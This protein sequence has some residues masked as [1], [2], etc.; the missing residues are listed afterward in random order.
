MCNV[1]STSCKI[2]GTLLE[3]LNETYGGKSGENLPFW[4]VDYARQ[5]W[6][7]SLIFN[8]SGLDWRIWFNAVE[9]TIN[10]AAE[11]KIGS[12]QIPGK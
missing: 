11:M 2:L 3:W 5:I 9:E 8:I 6:H 12:T 7:F 1:T 10:E 4:R